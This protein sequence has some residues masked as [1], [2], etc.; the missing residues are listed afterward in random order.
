MNIRK[1]IT[2]SRVID[3]Y[4]AKGRNH[5][6]FPDALLTPLLADVIAERSEG[7]RRRHE[8]LEACADGLP[9]RSRRLL[10]LRY[11]DRPSAAETA[12]QTESFVSHVL[13]KTL[14]F[15]VLALVTAA[16]L[17]VAFAMPSQNPG[18]APSPQFLA[19]EVH[20]FDGLVR[21][22]PRS[23]NR[24]ATGDAID[25]R[26]AQ[27]LVI[28]E[29]AVKLVGIEIARNRFIRNLDKPIINYISLPACARRNSDGKT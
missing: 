10:G 8:A 22:Q 26:T 19:S 14:A 3:F 13:W 18:S 24:G 4:R 20:V 25:L 23:R 16:C 5:V 2:R 29:R 11:V 9:E 6:V 15:S 21:V 7:H 28:D 1:W 12:N 27:A 17:L